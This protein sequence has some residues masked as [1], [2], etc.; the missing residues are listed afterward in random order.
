M[1]TQK[2]IENLK[3]RGFAARF[4]E[5]G[6]QAAEYIGSQLSGK[7]IGIGGS[8][9]VEQLHL[10]DILSKGNTVFWHWKQP[11]QEARAN[12]AN[13]QIY[14]SSANAIA[15]TGEIVNIDGSGNR[16]ASLM[17]GH[18]KVIIVAGVNKLAD[19]LDSAMQRARN[20]AAPLNAKRLGIKTPCALS[21][22]NKCFD[23]SS[24]DRICRGFSILSHKMQG[25]GEMEVVLINEDLGY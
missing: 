8:I 7:T 6:E 23:C 5:S 11:V 3:D 10:F 12:A 24:K 16:V 15:E 2:T 13:A 21:D 9:T 1:N 22:E 20:V 25:I 17:Y 14:I 4:F 19:S 18:E